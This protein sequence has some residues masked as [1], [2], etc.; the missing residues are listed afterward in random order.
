MSD[1]ASNANFVGPLP[2]ESVEYEGLPTKV[3]MTAAQR[4]NGFVP[5]QP[6]AAE[7]LNAELNQLTKLQAG[8]TSVVYDGASGTL[9]RAALTGAVTSAQDTNATAYGAIA[10]KSIVLNPTNAVAVPAPSAPLT[11]LQS[12]RS[13]PANN[14]LEWGAGAVG[15][16]A[17]SSNVLAATTFLDVSGTLTIPANTLQV[18]SRY[19]LRGT[20][21]F[22]RGATATALN[23]VSRL[24]VGANNLSVTSAAARTLNL[25]QGSVE[26][27][28]EFTVTGVN[29]CMAHILTTTNC[30]NVAVDGKVASAFSGTLA[31]DTTIANNINIA[32]Q[33]SAAVAGTAIFTAGGDVERR[34]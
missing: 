24:N 20:Y 8:S 30:D 14:A 12:V 18:G 6:I 2:A 11:Q 7:H 34:A 10:A 19:V 16:V 1:F 33:M 21:Q 17:T 15:A 31:V 27:V 4:A 5:E 13:N 22:A 26:V 28:A 32:A 23:L 3:A 9:K 29:V 25:F